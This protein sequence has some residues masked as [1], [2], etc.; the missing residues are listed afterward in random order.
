MLVVIKKKGERLPINDK[1]KILI[2]TSY[3]GTHTSEM[4]GDTRKIDGKREGSERH[5]GL[6]W[7]DSGSLCINGNPKRG[8]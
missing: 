4:K 5:F 8:Y 6:R 1:I 2:E 7:S 3:N